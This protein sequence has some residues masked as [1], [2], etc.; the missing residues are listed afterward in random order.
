MRVF[1]S[2]GEPSGDLHG[3]NL[4][5]HLRQLA[6][7]LRAEGLGGPRMQAAG[8]ELLRDMSDLAVMGLLP[9]LKKYPEFRALL[10][11]VVKH[12]ETE[13]PDCVVLIDYPG[14]NWHVARAAKKL[15]IP[16]VY[17]GLPQVWAWATWRVKKVQTLV[18]HA[19]CKLPFEE[20]WF[21]DRGVEATYVGHP[22]YDELASRS[23][24]HTF[25]ESLD[26]S[27]K[28]LVSILPGSRMQE[29]KNNLDM[30]LRAAK[31][32]AS[33]VPNI[34]FAIAS[35][36]DKQAAVARE[37]VAAAGLTI[38][39]YVNRTP[40]LIHAATATI[41]VSGSVSLELLYHAQPSVMV[42]KVS[43]LFSRM[44]RMLQAIRYMTLVNL[45]T[46]P[47]ITA[48]TNSAYDRHHPLDA[49]V[50]LPEY[51]T[52]RDKSPEVAE[53]VIEWLTDEPLRQQR[54]DDLAELRSRVSQTGA[55]RR[56]AD[57]IAQHVL[58]IT[59]QS[60]SRAA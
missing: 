58:G 38:P 27:Q 21:R 40:E 10:A 14:F 24:D 57:Y 11:R 59:P 19:L 3:S 44:V 60:H 16:V 29:V 6:P 31:I 25:V 45:L 17:Y 28:R 42:Y 22:Y 8:C 23:L 55:S 12:L 37:K 47:D 36:N 43:W 7:A 13:K 1:F 33:K 34:Q 20:K 41:A 46:A 32:V 18:D 56:A 30:Q 49:H 2:V 51:P 9:V 39:V 52:W 5:N 15:N 35:Y 26:L 4:I 48:G 50:L 53:H 54:I